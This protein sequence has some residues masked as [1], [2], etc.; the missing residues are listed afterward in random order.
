MLQCRPCVPPPACPALR[1][2]RPLRVPPSACHIQSVLSGG[3]W[4]HGGRGQW[5]LPE[6]G[7]HSAP[8]NAKCFLLTSVFRPRWGEAAE[9]TRVSRGDT[10]SE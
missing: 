10:A 8:A 1:A 4:V 5:T 2:P 7:V 3:A 6:G 9:V